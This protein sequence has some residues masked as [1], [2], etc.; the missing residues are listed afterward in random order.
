MLLN[1]SVAHLI[2]VLL[3]LIYSHELVLA[4]NMKQQKLDASTV[5]NEI[6]KSG[7]R[8]FSDK[9]PFNQ[10]LDYWDAIFDGI[11]TGDDEWLRVAEELRP[12]SDAT[13]TM[14]LEGSLGYAIEYNASGVLNVLK[15]LE[16][17]ESFVTT[18][19]KGDISLIFDICTASVLS[20]DEYNPKEDLRALRKREVALRKVARIDLEPSRAECLKAIVGEIKR[21]ESASNP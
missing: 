13:M 14:G 6:K 16:K 3:L 4:K 20:I 10:S 1:R 18:K 8:A 15:K 21:L 17:K 19:K 12:F 5:Q 2:L 7:A 11:A 9:H